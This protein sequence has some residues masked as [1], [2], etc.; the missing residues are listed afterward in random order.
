[1]LLKTVFPAGADQ[2]PGGLGSS[3]LWKDQAISQGCVEERPGPLD[4][5]PR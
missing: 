2:R 3:H 5:V 1:M 4:S